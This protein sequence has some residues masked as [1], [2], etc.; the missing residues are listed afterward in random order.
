MRFYNPEGVEPLRNTL[1]FNPFRVS[2]S[3]YKINLK[4]LE[5]N[6]TLPLY[7]CHIM[8]QKNNPLHGVTLQKML[9][10]LVETYRWEGMAYFVDINCFKNEPSIQSSLKFL[11]KTPWARLKVEELYLRSLEK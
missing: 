10:H 6:S 7:L 2:K 5:N 11:R 3:L 1:K 9:E 8:E 4:K